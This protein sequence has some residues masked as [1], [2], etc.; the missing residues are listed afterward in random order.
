PAD[1][2]SIAKREE[3]AVREAASA[4]AE[5]QFKEFLL[6]VPRSQQGHAILAVLQLRSLCER[7]SSGAKPILE[8]KPSP[9]IYRMM[10]E[11]ARA[12]PD[13]TPPDCKVT[14]SEAWSKYLDGL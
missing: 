12:F 5:K 10:V 8:K 4:I 6:T 3:A 1:P 13:W 9:E 2:A 7:I 11:M 14:I